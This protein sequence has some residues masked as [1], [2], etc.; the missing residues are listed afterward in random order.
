[1]AWEAWV[2]LA[3]IGLMVLALLRNWAKPDT[4][5]LG[6]LALVMTAGVF[7]DDLLLP[8]PQQ[9]VAG[10]GNQGLITIAVLFVVA[11]GLAKTGALDLLARPLLRRPRTVLGAQLRLMF[12]VAG[13]SAFMNNTPIV[14]MFVPV[15]SDWCRKTCLSPSKLMI[16]LSYAAIL[17]GTCTQ[18]GTSTNLVVSGLI[19]AAHDAGQLA[20]VKLEMFTIA[21]VGLP[22]SL[23]G[24]VYVLLASRKLLPDRLR[25]QPD[26]GDARRYT[27]EMLVTPGSGI[28]GKSI[29]QAGLR[30]LPGVFLAEIERHG[31][32]LVAVGG[33]QILHG[34]DRLIFVGVVESVVDLQ[35]IRGLVLAS[36]QVFKLSDPRPNRRL[37]EAV[38][39]STCPLV[40]QSIRAGRFRTVYDAV[41]IA[42]DRGGEHL[43]QKV[44]D[45]VLRPG[46]TLLM[47]THPRFVHRQ[48]NHRDFFLVSTVAGSEPIRHDRAY[49]ALA[50]LVGM[51]AVVTLTPLTLLNAALLAAGLMVVTRCI[52]MEEARGSID[53]RVL[54]AIGAALGIGKALD[55]SG[56]AQ[57]L[58]DLLLNLAA[59]LGPHGVLAGIY[60]LAM[61]INMMIGNIA[62][63][64]LAFPIAQVAVAEQGLSFMPF[65][66]AIMMAASASYATPISYPTNLMVYS[67][68]GYR[69][70]D[71]VRFGLPLNLLIMTLVVIL[72]PVIWPF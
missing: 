69:F 7:S 64:V 21:A 70:S 45:V 36:E 40:G 55:H 38:V 34:N 51:V 49:L 59:P 16:P 54:L 8:T 72:T 57:G 10:F 37:V 15:V 35:K 63:A 24:I 47:E 71:Y 9:A 27:V 66:I 42:V 5:L 44:G 48:R 29:E 58:A 67:A 6:G 3:T 65:A 39:S 18:I 41:V 53:W 31:E 25:R 60:L 1:M 46:D 13:L 52:S 17:G 19:D 23:L 50:I 68:G 61:I 2:T 43:Y 4:V 33:E 32:R 56:A 22:A 62:S 28:E 26:L 11:A 14:A 12:P 20:E 30:H